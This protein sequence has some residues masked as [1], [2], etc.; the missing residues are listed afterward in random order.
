MKKL[1]NS[2]KLT[3]EVVGLDVHKSFIAYSLLDRRGQER[4]SGRIRSSR[5]TRWAS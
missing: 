3:V 4:E 1:P 5:A 2:H